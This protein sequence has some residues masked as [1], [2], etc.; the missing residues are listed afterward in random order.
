MTIP[1]LCPST[2]K[3]A[4]SGPRCNPGRRKKFS[5]TRRTKCHNLTAA[6]LGRCIKTS[7][8]KKTPFR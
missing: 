8:L 4:S 6:T 1:M 2:D 3:N 5:I 7:C